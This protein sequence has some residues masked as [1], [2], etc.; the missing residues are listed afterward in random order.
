MRTISWQITLVLITLTIFILLDCKNT[1]TQ[2]KYSEIEVK[3]MLRLF[4]VHYINKN[5]ILDQVKSDSIL[6]VYCS[7][8]LI[9]HVN[10]LY[11]EQAIDAD[12]FVNSQMIDVRMLE[13]IDFAKDVHKDYV[14]YVRYTYGDSKN[15]IKLSVIKEKEI[16]K[17]NHI[18]I[19]GIDE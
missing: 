3:E 11:A 18:F 15:E 1:S 2:E 16:Y 17:V 10:K 12:P 8:K 5:A 4:Y 6:K 14:Y 13:H 7:E 9:F 19:P